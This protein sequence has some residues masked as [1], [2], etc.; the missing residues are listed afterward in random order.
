MKQYV[1]LIKIQIPSN[2]ASFPLA[3]KPSLEHEQ[4]LS[5]YSDACLH[6][7][8]LSTK[9]YIQDMEKVELNRPKTMNY[10]Y[11][12]NALCSTVVTLVPVLVFFFRCM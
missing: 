1:L 5:W 7:K 3:K 12:K 2:R 4:Y 11:R 9:C 8:F 6:K 10:I